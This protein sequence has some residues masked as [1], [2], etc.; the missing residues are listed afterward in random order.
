MVVSWEA[1]TALASLLSSLAVLAAVIVAVRQVRV[2]AAQVEHLRKATQLDGTM[3]IFEKLGGPEQQHAR[4]FIANELPAL[5]EDPVRREAMKQVAYLPEKFPE[6]LALRYFEMVGTYV[7]HGLLDEEIIFDYWYPAVIDTW[8]RLE[9]LGVIAIHRAAAGP[10]MWE[11]FED[12]YRRARR[13]VAVRDPSTE[14]RAWSGRPTAP[15]GAPEPAGT[16][17]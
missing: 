1:V 16:K 12:L 7:K 15:T 2:G 11:N 13:W 10:L 3:K 5:L 14:P 4:H 6:M 17:S 9:D 8:E